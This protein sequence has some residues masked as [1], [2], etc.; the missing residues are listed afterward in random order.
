MDI[1]GEGTFEM[2]AE[3]LS[4]L[5]LQIPPYRDLPESALLKLWSRVGDV[6]YLSGHI[7]DIA[8]EPPLRGRLGAELNVDQ[9]REAAVRVARNLLATLAY[10][11]GGLDHTT[12]IVKLLGFVASDPSFT[13]QPSVI[14]AASEIFVALWGDG[15]ARSAVGVAQL[16]LGV[17][18]EIELIAEVRPGA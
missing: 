11:A 14:D 10:A 13:D 18:V 17:P 3:T 8:G 7:P 16:P 9:G 6:V 4:R 5:E 2:I 12:R 15:H 1:H